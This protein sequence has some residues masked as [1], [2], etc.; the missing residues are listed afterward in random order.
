MKD[1]APKP[2][3]VLR[4]RMQKPLKQEIRR[5][6]A[7]EKVSASRWTRG[8]LVHVVNERLKQDKGKKNG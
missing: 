2:T 6:A 8:I 5:L 1:K 7:V 3:H 4:V